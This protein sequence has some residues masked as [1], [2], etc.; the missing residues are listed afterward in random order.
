MKLDEKDYL[1]HY[2]ILRKSG[3]YPWGSGGTQSARNKKFLDIVTEL[4]KEGMTES[5][6]ARGYQL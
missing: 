3:R 6:I 4:R 5:E 1:A 2:G